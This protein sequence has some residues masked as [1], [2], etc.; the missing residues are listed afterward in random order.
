MVMGLNEDL[1][2]H[3][4]SLVWGWPL[5]GFITVTGIALSF[6]LSGIQFRYFFASW[7][8][9][10]TPEKGSAK[11][12]ITPL[13]AFMNTLS[14]SIGNGSLTG[15]ATAIYSGGPGAALWV[16]LFGLISMPLRFA[17][18][19]CG[20]SASTTHADGKVHGGP[21]AYI[22]NAPGGSFLV[23]IYVLGVLALTFFS[24]CGMQCQSITGGMVALTG[25]PAVAIAASLFLF[26]AYVIS[27]GAERVLRVSD[28]IVP[29]KVGLFFIMT[30]I[31]LVYHAANIIP[32]LLLIFRSA[33]QLDAVQ[34][35]A[36]GFAVQE[37][38]RFALSRVINATE[39]GLGTSGIL[40]G[41]TGT[42]DSVRSGI[43]SMA[44]A[45]VSNYL[46]CFMLMLFI[47]A[48]GA[49]ESGIEGVGMTIAAY[50]TVFGSAAALMVTI[51]SMMFGL[52]VMVAYVYIG[53]EAWSFITGGRYIW[54]YSLIF[55]AFSLIGSLAQVAVLWNLIDISNGFL[56][57]ANLYGIWLMVPKM[58]AAVRAYSA[59][60]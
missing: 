27:G 4:G 59:R 10:L 25:L 6:I 11:S 39:A 3:L 5:I 56:V 55:C 17:E 53:R 30:T 36:A 49:W 38:V 26:L 43:M 18:V 16:A 41:G 12:S 50:S 37:V 34:A 14:A 60:A 45:F 40:Y 42:V 20:T 24:G 2:K 52:G 58:R 31:A 57:A 47:V 1:I 21:I 19:F 54:L 8:Y 33:L 13:Q 46:V 44:T 48:S 29:V 9:L 35:G 51:L 7:R 28:M 32:A 23:Y 22:S 15:M